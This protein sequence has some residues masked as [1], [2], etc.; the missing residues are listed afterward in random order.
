MRS[1][2]GNYKIKPRPMFCKGGALSDCLKS[3]FLSEDTD[4][5]VISSNRQ[6]FY[7]PE[8]ENLNSVDWKLPRNWGFL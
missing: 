2:F 4:V 5:F 1:P 7:F 8:L 6:T 3:T